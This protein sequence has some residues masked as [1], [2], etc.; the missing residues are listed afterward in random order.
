MKPHTP[1]RP[2]VHVFLCD[3]NVS[4]RFIPHWIQRVTNRLRFQLIGLKEKNIH[5]GKYVDTALQKAVF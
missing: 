2:P 4:E 1:E 3:P 5:R